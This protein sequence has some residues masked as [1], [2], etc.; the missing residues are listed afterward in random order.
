MRQYRTFAVFLILIIGL[1]IRSPARTL[2]VGPQ[3]EKADCPMSI[4]LTAK[5]DCGYLIVPEDRTRPNSRAIRVAVA[6][7][8]SRSE[9]PL[10]DPV[11]YL[12]GGPGNH[13][14]WR[15]FWWS[16]TPFLE[17]R[18]VIIVDQRG[19]GFSRPLADC[20]ELND[21]PIE[22]LTQPH[23]VEEAAAYHAEHA[24]QCRDRLVSEG[25]NLA[26]YT[27]A[28]IAADLNDLRIA[29]GYKQ[30]NLFG[31]SA[32]T[33]AALTIMRDFPEGVRTAILDSVYMPPGADFHAQLVPNAAQTFKTVFE[34][35][36]AD[37]A[38]NNAY[39]KLES[40]FLEVV[41][42]L[43]AQ[44][45]TFTV[46]HP[47]TG[48]SIEAHMNGAA[49]VG[50]FYRLLYDDSEL[51]I[52]PRLIYE[53]HKRNTYFLPPLMEFP[54]AEPA[55]YR[56]AMNQS[57]H[58]AEQAPFTTREK[59]A[60]AGAKVD[61]RFN[62]H[63]HWDVDVLAFQDFCQRW[64]V[65]PDTSIENQ[66]VVSSIPTLILAGQFDP[67]S[68]PI[69][70]QLVAKTLSQSYFFEFPHRG[71]FM[72]QSNVNRCAWGIALAFINNPAIKPDGSCIAQGDRFAFV[73]DVFAPPG[74]YNLIAGIRANGYAP[75]VFGPVVTAAATFAGTL[76]FL[77]I[78][79]ISR[80]P[81][82][83]RRLYQFA[84][85]VAGILA[86]INLFFIVATF[87][88]I[89][90]VAASNPNSLA[91][92]LPASFAP[93]FY[94]PLITVVLGAGLSVAALAARNRWPL[95]GRICYLLVSLAALVL[96][97]WL[98]YWKL[99]PF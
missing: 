1:I 5:V 30:W 82:G 24:L 28:D 39:P 73:T 52:L 22:T 9:N 31:W 46:D 37:P 96:V 23:T 68:P 88:A 8:H 70:G 90:S 67:A 6:I 50:L 94:V 89:I 93:L 63:Y 21:V 54:L 91:F 43:N 92:G 3:F 57:I 10:P 44:P 11:V 60:A 53:V 74:L 79:I 17:Q 98:G 36:A 12:H 65:R 51:P 71:H 34:S 33:R 49:F 75:Q 42:Q 95:L 62:G 87:R 86:A 27:N 19:T 16:L 13:L 20:P 15:V 77:A 7:T 18:D 2:A 64:G 80:R 32:G 72:L 25:M 61:P 97:I 85:L 58:C 45:L 81:R 56:V 55:R 38:C 47:F 4:P 59:I 69:H 78:S 14:L 83:A 48:E 40:V 84:A 99:L 66:P 26:A 76:L 35:C 41:D 29:L